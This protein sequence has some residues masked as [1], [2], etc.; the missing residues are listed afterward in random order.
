[1]VPE[2]EKDKKLIEL[3]NLDP[4][5]VYTFDLETPYASDDNGPTYI[6]NKSNTDVRII[7][8]SEVQTIDA[9]G[10]IKI[11][12]DKRMWVGVMKFKFLGLIPRMPSLAAPWN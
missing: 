2:E 6:R 9:Q 1:M 10:Q 5:K 11:D 7:N 8:K 12:M 3:F 4:S